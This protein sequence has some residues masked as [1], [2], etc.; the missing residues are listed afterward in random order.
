MELLTKLKEH[1]FPFPQKKDIVK[2]NVP[3]DRK[4]RYRLSMD[5]PYIVV[6]VNR[7]TKEVVIVKDGREDDRGVEG[8]TLYISDIEPYEKR[9]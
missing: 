4:K 7:K 1:V 3:M 2:V 9:S 8:W 6:S 5:I